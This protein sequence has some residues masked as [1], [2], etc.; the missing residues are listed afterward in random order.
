MSTEPKLSINFSRTCKWISFCWILVGSKPKWLSHFC[1][2][3]HIYS[4]PKG[5]SQTVRRGIL[6]HLYYRDYYYPLLPGCI[7]GIL[8]GSW[9]CKLQTLLWSG[10]K[11]NVQKSQY[12]LCKII[13]EGLKYRHNCFILNIYF[14][15]VSLLVN[16]LHF[17]GFK[18]WWNLSIRNKF[19]FAFQ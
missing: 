12:I 16:P 5:D 11:R 10:Q 6:F 9:H 7:S 17:C 13:T 2:I 18:T 4:N 8:L 3:M 15:D 1:F 19:S 14:H